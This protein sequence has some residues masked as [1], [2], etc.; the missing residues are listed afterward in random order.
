VGRE[1]TVLFVVPAGAT[2]LTAIPI[3][4]PREDLEKRVGRFRRLIR[5][6]RPD[7]AVETAL[8]KEARDLFRDLLGPAS[9]LLQDAR[10]L[11]V[12]PDGPLHTLPFAALVVGTS[13]EPPRYLVEWKPVHTAVSATAYAE[14]KRPGPRSE[15]RRL[16]LVA[17]GDPRYPTRADAIA[18]RD[19]VL[20]SA[21]K[22][23]LGFEPLP[24]T[25][26]EVEEITEPYGDRARRYL[27]D[28]ATEERAKSIGN[29]VRYVHFACHAQIDEASPL[30]S[31]L[32]LTIPP[33]G[34]AGRDNGLLQA[35]EILD[36]VRIDADLVTLSAC[37]TALGRE[38]G[39]EGLVSLTRAFQYA[40]ARS[41]LASLWKV[42]DEST[43]ELMKRFYRHLGQGLPTD[44]SL[45]AAQRELLHDG[46]RFAHPFAWA[47]F[48]LAGDWK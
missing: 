12:C 15:P 5:H 6:A 11:L 4:F 2:S 13:A 25:R 26:R 37:E 9:P 36:G 47:G 27:G 41:V 8:V 21:L 10:R 35:W 7:G 24:S 17:F 1:R 45:R 46:G 18:S 33:A 38:A 20:R 23:G 44:E 14:L 39:G 42:A 3:P 32:V 22:K 19:P 48:Q 40:G 28:E 29:D 34:E 16:E 43:A 31:A 30:S